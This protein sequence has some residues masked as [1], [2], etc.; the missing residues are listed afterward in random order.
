[1]EVLKADNSLYSPESFGECL[2]F[3]RESKGLT[4]EYFAELINV[5]DRMIRKWESGVNYPKMSNLKRIIDVLEVSLESILL[6]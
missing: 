3:F 2:K 6:W 5:S 1:M 4:Q